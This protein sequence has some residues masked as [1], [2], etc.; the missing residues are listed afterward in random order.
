MTSPQEQERI[1]RFIAAYPYT[2][3]SDAQANSFFNN[4]I[5][6]AQYAWSDEK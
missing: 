5:D 6:P 3:K 4:F 1:E 2:A